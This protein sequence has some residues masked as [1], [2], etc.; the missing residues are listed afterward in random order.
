MEILNTKAIKLISPSEAILKV[1]REDGKEVK[2]TITDKD[3]FYLS[4]KAFL[5]QELDSDIKIVEF[6]RE[7]LRK[8]YDIDY[9]D[10]EHILRGDFDFVRKQYVEVKS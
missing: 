6:L 10:I 9:D 2:Q 5:E 8:D 7:C 1:Y 4:K 3:T